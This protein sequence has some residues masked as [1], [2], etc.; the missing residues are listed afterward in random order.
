M[1]VGDIVIINFDNKEFVDFINKP[2]VN[3]INFRWDRQRLENEFLK[4]VLRGDYKNIWKLIEDKDVNYSWIS[5]I[6]TEFP[7]LIPTK[8]LITRGMIR[9]KKIDKLLC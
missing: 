7:V 6:P 5:H 9:D 3:D 8:H 1:L 2:V 4:S